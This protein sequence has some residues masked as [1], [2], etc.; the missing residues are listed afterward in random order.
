MTAIE[1]KVNGNCLNQICMKNQTGNR[2]EVTKQYD[3]RGNFV[4]RPIPEN[5]TIVGVYGKIKDGNW[6]TN[7]GFIVMDNSGD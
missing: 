2:V 1:V 5:H 6:I 3:A 4:A 7:L